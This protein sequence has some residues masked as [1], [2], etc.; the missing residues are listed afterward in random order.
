MVNQNSV[1]KAELSKSC[2][3]TPKV[4][5][6][7][8]F[9]IYDHMSFYV[10]D[11][12]VFCGG[13]KRP[14]L[15]SNQC[16]GLSSNQGANWTALPNIPRFL[17]NAAK[18]TIKDKAFL[19]GGF[20][21]EPVDTVYSFDSKMEKWEEEVKLSLGRSSACAVSYGDTVYVT[22]GKKTAAA[23]N[24]INL[25]TVEKLRIGEDKS[26]IAMPDLIHK[27]HSHSDLFFCQG[28]KYNNLLILKSNLNVKQGVS[29][30]VQ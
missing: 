30:V 22:G 6:R 4:M 8:P 19:I 5:K 2:L 3:L 9:A 25:K 29:M 27:R 11:K 12:F 17:S 21:K 28:I 10:E 20:E 1:E 23:S 7:M 26:W 18:T 14:G 24:S 15:L 16:F 13:H